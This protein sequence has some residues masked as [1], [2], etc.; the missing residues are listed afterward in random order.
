[1]GFKGAVPG[2]LLGNKYVIFI[3]SYTNF[4]TNMNFD[5]SMPVI[6]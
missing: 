6:H 5:S 4:I 2:A 1:M 3:F